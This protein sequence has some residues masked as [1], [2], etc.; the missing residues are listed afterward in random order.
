MARGPAAS[1]PH[2]RVFVLWLVGGVVAAVL[3]FALFG[4]RADPNDPEPTT[5]NAS[6][7]GTKA[8]YLLLPQ[9]GYGADRWSSPPTDLTRLDAARTTLVI[10]EPT[11][12]FKDLAVVQ[13][14][15]EAFM[16]R[17]GSVLATGREGARLLPGGVTA[18]PTG[19]LNGLCLTEGEGAGTLGQPQEVHMQEPVRWSAEG[20]L[21]RVR[22]RCG[23][24]AVVVTYPVGKG[25]AVWWSSP[26]PMTNQG[27]KD[28]PSL[29]L[30]LASLGPPS[31]GPVS[32]SPAAGE[33]GR[34]I[35]FDE[36]FHAEHETVGS[37]LAGL[38]WWPLTGQCVAAAV[39][40]VLSLGRRNGPLR[41]PVG[42]PRTSPIE[43]AES[44]GRL[45]ARA[46]A[47][48]AATGAAE[49]RLLRFLH[50]SCGLSRETLRGGPA[51]IAEA[52]QAR[53]GGDW[54]ALEHDLQLATDG[55][56][57]GLGARGALKLVQAL[58]Q[59]RQNLAAVIAAGRVQRTDGHG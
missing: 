12:P 14:A 28:D 58:E 45:Y 16:E 19:M 52:V 27:L 36:W 2:E 10:T 18:A 34:T 3:L 55:A 44:M 29:A 43:F 37:T 51:V 9:L 39:L 46:G 32:A 20:P 13:K 25:Q 5:Y 53:F 4:P 50:E 57:G 42:V 6:S 33:T 47:T 21:Y 23:K 54:K 15:L 38:P 48:G 41:T 17:G 59:D 1:R 26:Q 11:L 56:G 31:A 24:D 8:A 49:S 22:Q 7:A 40:L 35:L 30:L